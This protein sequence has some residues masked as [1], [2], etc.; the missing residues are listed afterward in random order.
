[1]KDDL[2]FQKKKGMTISK[3]WILFLSMLIAQLITGGIVGYKIAKAR[4]EGAVIE[5]PYGMTMYYT[6]GAYIILCVIAFY[7]NKKELPRFNIPSFQRVGFAIIIAI[8][9]RILSSVLEDLPFSFITQESIEQMGQFNYTF[10]VLQSLVIIFFQVGFIGHGLLR[11]YEFITA[12][13]TTTLVSIVHFEPK[14]ILSMI[15]LVGIMLYIYYKT[16]SFWLVIIIGLVYMYIDVVMALFY[17]MNIFHNNNWRNVIIGNDA[18][19]YSLVA[20]CVL[21]TAGL[22]YIISR[23]DPLEW[24]RSDE[25]PEF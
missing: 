18:S 16:S 14:S 11:N 13:I 15:V 20:F 12:A 21:G 22:L 1:M 5:N 23:I 3:A 10:I 8:F 24:Q 4:G 7:I 25:L 17:D 19:Y 9:I 2:I 6:L